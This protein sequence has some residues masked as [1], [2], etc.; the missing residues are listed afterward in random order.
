MVSVVAVRETCAP[1]ILERFMSVRGAETQDTARHLS[2]RNAASITSPS[3][4]VTRGARTERKV[5]ARA[6]VMGRAGR[7][8]VRGR[9]RR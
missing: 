1:L 4:R 6:V 9:Q 3:I 5:R 7:I 2:K 8:E